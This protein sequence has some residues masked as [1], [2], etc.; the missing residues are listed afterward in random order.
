LAW[1]RPKSKHGVRVVPLLP[2]LV[3]VLR[4]HREQH[5][6]GP[7]DL[8]WHVDGHPIPHKVDEAEWRATMRQVGLPESCT[9]HWARH[10]CATLLMSAGVATEV[11][12]EICGHG[13]VAVTSG[14]IHVSSALAQQGMAKLGELLA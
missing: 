13:T 1:V 4:R 2:E 7:H 12:Q 6:P 11:I 5:P 10:S 9:L 8:V 14:Y 3:T